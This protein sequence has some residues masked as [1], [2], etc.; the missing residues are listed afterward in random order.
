M[1]LW[2]V[3]LVVLYGVLLCLFQHAD[4]RKGSIPQGYKGCQFHRVIKDFMIQGGDFMKVRDML[5]ALTINK[6]R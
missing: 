2:M 3:G 1:Q 6:I 4:C 5:V